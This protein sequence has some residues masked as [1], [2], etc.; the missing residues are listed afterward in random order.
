M[1]IAGITYRTKA[2]SEPEI[3]DHLNE[4]DNSFIPPLSSRVDLR[5]YAKKIVNHAVT[6][7]A[8][9]ERKLAGLLA[10]YFNNSEK[11]VG[12]ITNVSVLPEFAGKGIGS[13]LLLRCF[14]HALKENYP[15]ICL[16]VNRA[17]IKAISL[18]RKHNF[19]QTDEKGDD[20]IMKWK[21]SDGKW[22]TRS[23]RPK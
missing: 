8:W 15:E 22:I 14:H 6:F 9:N 11:R 13:K 19:T 21:N 3:L 10:A 4:C 23:N 17:N 1:S 7:E 5:S 12:Y 2:A 20:L 18:Y 16:E